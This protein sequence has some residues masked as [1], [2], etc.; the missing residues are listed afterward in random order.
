MRLLLFITCMFAFCTP[1]VMATEPLLPLPYLVRAP[2]EKTDQ[3]PVLILL[4][5]LGSNEQDLFSLAN[6]VPAHFLV[7]AAR[8]PLQ[9]GFISFAWYQVDFSSGKPVYDR[10]QEASSRALLIQFIE[11]VKANYQIKGKVYLGGFSQGAIMSYSIGLTRP[12]L[13]HG[14]ALMSGRLLEEIKPQLATHQSLQNLK[15]FIAHG[16]QDAVLNIQY[17]RSSK[18]YLGSLGLQPTYR[19]YPAPH[20][21]T[22]EMVQDLV[23]WINSH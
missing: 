22:K 2:L 12:D 21:I 4:H 3:T 14:I 5:G 23:Q 18:A 20:T 9:L 1:A 6:Q 13:V 10:E 17:A 7:I 15:V 8:A 19:E 11:Q 16:T